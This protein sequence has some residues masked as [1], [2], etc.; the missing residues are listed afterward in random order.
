VKNI[1]KQLLYKKYFTECA[2]INTSTK[3]CEEL[4]FKAID[5]KYVKD[6]ARINQLYIACLNA[7]SISQN[8]KSIKDNVNGPFSE[9]GEINSNVITKMFYKKYYVKPQAKY[10]FP[11]HGFSTD[12]GSDELISQ[13]E[14]SLNNK[15]TIFLSAGV[16]VGKTTFIHK[17][18]YDFCNNKN[19]IYESMAKYKNIPA[20]T[21]IENIQSET[22]KEN[23]D[24]IILIIDELD[25]FSYNQERFIFDEGGYLDFNKE[26]KKTK[27]VVLGLLS[28]YSQSNI[29]IIFSVR[30][31]VMSHFFDDDQNS[32]HRDLSNNSVIY[33]LEYSTENIQNVVGKRLELMIDILNNIDV[34]SSMAKGT[35]KTLLEYAEK[36]V[37][38]FEDINLTKIGII[39]DLY[40]NATQGFRSII[41]LYSKLTYIPEIFK[42]HFSNNILI[43]YLLSQ[44]K[45]YSQILPRKCNRKK[46]FTYPNMFLSVS[47]AE[48][49]NT[50][51]CREPSLLTYW[52]KILVL[53]YI[54]VNNSV[55]IKTILNTFSNYKDDSDKVKYDA[56]LVQLALGSLGTTNEYNCL[57]YNFPEKDIE[58]YDEFIDQTTVTLTRRGKYIIQK[59]VFFEYNHFELFIDDWQLPT[60]RLDKVYDREN[61]IYPPLEYILNLEYSYEYLSERQKNNTFYEFILNKTK[62][63]IWYTYIFELSLYQELEYYNIDF[64][65]EYDASFFDKRRRNIIN[66]AENILSHYHKGTKKELEHFNTMC[67]NTKSNI[68]SF[69]TEVFDKGVYIICDYDGLCKT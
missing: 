22:S 23:S 44:Y 68:N 29:T 16:G 32:P 26:I 9:T 7:D 25:S 33:E 30:P 46:K 13:V 37:S 14:T 4:D 21:I 50:R 67:S 2:P 49:N 51:S 1:E 40:N 34:D 65:T 57:E 5:K 47:N 27:D 42:T 6:I 62:K 61:Y 48:A 10:S 55:S 52:L 64:A 36:I 45:I 35:M 19:I 12:L 39:N 24:D 38:T 54:L 59:N 56:H 31:Y 8:I 20:C 66:S 41:D 53:K 3:Y 43:V 58:S 18:R 60:P 17:L 69:F 28:A 11:L 15:Q 63:M